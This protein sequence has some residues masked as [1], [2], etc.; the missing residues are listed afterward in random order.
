VRL[1]DFGMAKVKDGRV[2]TGVGL[3]AGT[4]QYM[5][6]EQIRQAPDIGPKADIYGLGAVLFKMLTGRLPFE[7]D[8]LQ[9]IVRMHL[10]E[11]PPKPS[12]FAKVSERMDAIVL[13]CMEKEPAKRPASML[14]L[15]E[16]LR[17]IAE[18][19]GPE[20]MARS[21]HFDRVPNLPIAHGLGVVRFVVGA[22]AS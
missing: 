7:S 17:P 6:P 15:R 16:L 18:Q 20:V 12:Q 13:A 22:D 19:V 8:S 9:E 14:E 3:L 2:R 21:L 11:S 5:S 1:L 10:T 4:P